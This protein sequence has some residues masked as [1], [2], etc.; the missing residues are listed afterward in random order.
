M[1]II[2]TAALCSHSVFVKYLTHVACF[3]K[4]PLQL[5]SFVH[6]H[7]LETESWCC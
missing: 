5:F 4:L 2:I 3:V 1:L 6:E 7:P